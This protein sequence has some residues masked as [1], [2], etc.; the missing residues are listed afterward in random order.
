MKLQVIGIE[1]KTGTFENKD[2]GKTYDYDN[3]NLHCVGKNMKVSGQCVR[4][5]KLKVPEAA[6]LVAAVGGDANQIVG[7][8]V[9]FE[10][11]SYG[12]VVSYDLVK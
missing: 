3:F 11:G 10:F 4:E 1:R 2:T 9:D 6:E 5:V 12:K 7:H 8:V